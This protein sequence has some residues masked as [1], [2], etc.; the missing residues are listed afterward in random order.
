MEKNIGKPTGLFAGMREKGWKKVLIAAVILA[1]VVGA[2]AVAILEK[3]SANPAFCANCHIMKPYYQS[4]H[5]SSL[6]ANKH[7]KAG[8]TCHQC[9]QNTIVGQAGEGLKY[10]TGNYKTPLDKLQVDRNFCLKCHDFDTVKS[11]T[12]FDESNPHDSHNGEQ[13]CTVCHSMHQKSKVMCAQ[14]HTFNW[15]DKLDSSW[16][17]N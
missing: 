17:T 9:H 1:V 5:D 6:L 3:A 2:G 16:K 4:W 14:C 11:K 13:N 12:N 7:A 8:V 10:I 15:F